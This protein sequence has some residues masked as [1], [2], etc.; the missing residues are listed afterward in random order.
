MAV[1]II[2]R[3]KNTTNKHDKNVG[4]GNSLKFLGPRTLYLQGSVPVK[5]NV[6]SFAHS[7]SLFIQLTQHRMSKGNCRPSSN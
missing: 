4:E 6:E 5:N 7:A 1:I 3:I 2:F